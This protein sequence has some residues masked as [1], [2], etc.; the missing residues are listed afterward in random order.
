MACSDISVIGNAIRLRRSL[1]R[2]RRAGIEA[3]RAGTTADAA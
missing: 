3:A 1:A 2:E